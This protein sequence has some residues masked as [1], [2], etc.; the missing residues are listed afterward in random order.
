MG[1]LTTSLI[2]G[3]TVLQAGAKVAGASAT[4]RAAAENRRFAEAAADDAI[5]RGEEQA[6]RY[7][8]DLSRLLGR[9]RAV[10]AGAQGL[11]PNQGT[12]GQLRQ[13]T[14][15]F[16]EQDMATIRLNA[17][18]EAWGI[19]TQASINQRAANAQATAMTI[20]AAGTLLGG[21]TDAWQEYSTRRGPR[22]PT[23]LPALP[24]MGNI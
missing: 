12:A 1:A 7:G 24:S 11:D 17:A 3:S 15:A 20:G 13:Q 4:R 14:E 18:R 16:G 9:Q 5:A 22:A 2:I 21:A 10:I 23:T 19:R 8:M 6:E